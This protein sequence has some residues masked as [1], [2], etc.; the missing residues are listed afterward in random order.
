MAKLTHDAVK[1]IALVDRIAEING[2]LI[3]EAESE[4]NELIEDLKL[5]RNRLDTAKPVVKIVSPSA[6]LANKL[7]DKN[8]ANSQLRSLYEFQVT[9]PISK[10]Q[11]IIQHCDLICFIYYFKHNINKQHQQ[12]IELDRQN[13]IGSILLVRQPDNNI[14]NANL[15]GWLKA[16]DCWLD[17]V[18]LPLDNFIDLNQQRDIDIYQQLL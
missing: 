18:Q 8:L 7:K 16:Q 1:S 13:N 2:Y 11:Q 4:F 10:I 14:E 6:T 5:F 3:E 12:L 17:K 9:A 15:S